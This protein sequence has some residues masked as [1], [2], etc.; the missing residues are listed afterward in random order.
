MDSVSEVMFKTLPSIRV[1]HKLKCMRMRISFNIISVR[2]KSV[3]SASVLDFRLV[4]KSADNFTYC[5]LRS[6]Q[7]LGDCDNGMFHSSIFSFVD[8]RNGMSVVANTFSS[9]KIRDVFLKFSLYGEWS[10]LPSNPHEHISII[11]NSV[12]LPDC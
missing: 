8:K 5:R 10:E 12:D 6:R 2:L 4:M 9:L 11:S 7:N 3:I 1:K